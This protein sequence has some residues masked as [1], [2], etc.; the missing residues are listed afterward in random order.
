MTH[1]LARVT[2]AVAA[3]LITGV[4][5]DLPLSARQQRAASPN[6][7]I[8][9]FEQIEKLIREEIGQRRLPG[10]VV[11]IGVG[12]RVV[13]QKAIGSRSLVPSA[14]PMTL[15]TI[16]D[17]ASLTKVVAT[18]TSVMMLVEQGRLRLVDRVA[19]F[20]PGFERYGKADITIRHLL[21][22]VSGLRPDVD[23]G[24]SW[25]GTE[26]AI[27][28]AV[29]EVPTAPA[30]TRFVYSDINFFLL[31]EIVHRI[32]GQPLDEFTREHIFKPLGMNDTM[33]NPPASLIGRI[34]PTE[35]CTPYGW[36]CDGPERRMLRGVVHDPTARR[37]NGVAGHAGLFSTA[38]DLA[39]FSRMLLHNG[40][41]KGERI[42]APL[43]VAK[44]TTPVPAS[45]DRNLRAL[46]WDVDSSY[47]GNRGELLPIGSFG[48]TGF[49][50]TS[51]WIDPMT[52]MFVVF[53]SNRVHPDGK[54]DVTPLRARVATI[55]ASAIEAVPP[56]IRTTAL[57]GRDF[58]GAPL[59]VPRPLTPVV[60]GLDALRAERF[61]PLRGKRV[62]L[63]TNHTGRARDG[64]S[65]I[66]LMFESQELRLAALFSP[67]HGIRGVLDANVPS[68]K[69][70]KTGLVIHSLYG[71]TRR[72]TAAMLDGLDAIVIDLQ[73]IGA[74]FYTYMTTMAFVMEEAAKRNLPVFVL[75]RPNPIN[76]FAIEGPGLDKSLL[77]FIGYFP[78]MPVRHG[79]TLGE[80]ARLF[81]G[82]NKIGA[83]LTVI[84]MKNWD[85][86]R[87]FD[88]TG[89]PWINPS[90]NM[91]NLLQATLYPGVGA[92]EY[93]NVS[94]G[95][96][97]D[98]P[99][100]QIGA[101]W[102]D[103]VRL[104]ETLNGRAITGVRFYPVRFTPAS[105]KYAK[106]ECQG[107]FIVVTDRAAL[108]PVRLGVELAS[109][110][111]RLYGAKYELEP[112][113]RLFGS[114]DVVT[115]I[116]AGED[117]AAIAGSWA[118]AEARWRL[119]RAKYLLYR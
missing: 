62:G 110:L 3:L 64:A 75:D 115:R 6:L 10:A 57:T 96:G 59:V 108:R 74:R 69:D 101:P 14:E 97:T 98:T 56:A 12:D 93:S 40:S 71:E 19:A 30:G 39:L 111:H 119:L 88:E 76:G 58:G 63:V 83:A 16:F 41:L 82:E 2:A 102:I 51:L 32:S 35:S 105:S 52:R 104:A 33:F 94:V 25:L 87:W 48:H 44:M 91:R 5:H 28:L 11:L 67:E 66:D 60:S 100:E 70:Q 54:G 42:L 78:G 73:D 9:R 23:L 92:I 106:E 99:F 95:R 49:T 47:S 31:G 55:A 109:A 7:D 1:R 17:V 117:P 72:P 86:T 114:R 38:A 21:T 90:P 84:P 116:R 80:L 15:D 4:A 8:R 85:R 112:A 22:H 89:L 13:Y 36:P 37:M 34:A 68:E 24:D 81:N 18:T 43:T 65:A 113:E 53:L 61:A 103:G 50:G 79:M 27:Q 107:V 77:E 46:G 118:A 45:E 29:E 26:A 20:I